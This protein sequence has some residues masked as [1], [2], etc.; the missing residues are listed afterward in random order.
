MPVLAWP[1]LSYN[2]SC[3]PWL[4]IIELIKGHIILIFSEVKTN[5]TPLEFWFSPGKNGSK[6]ERSL[7]MGTWLPFNLHLS[8][9][10]SD[11]QN[12]HWNQSF[13]QLWLRSRSSILSR[14]CSVYTTICE[15]YFARITSSLRAT[16]ERKLDPTLR[17]QTRWEPSP[18]NGVSSFDTKEKKQIQL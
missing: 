11:T 10:V 16:E 13:L 3:N 7:S 15:Q 2:L 8:S 4:F 1:T 5:R 18:V 14:M 17:I 6:E 9:F 12:N